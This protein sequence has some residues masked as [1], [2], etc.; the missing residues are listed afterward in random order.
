MIRANRVGWRA[1][2][3]LTKTGG[4]ATVVARL[5]DS[6]YADAAGA[7]V[8]LGRMSAPIHSRAIQV[9]VPPDCAAGSRVSV[10][11]TTL[12]PW[13]PTL[14]RLAPDAAV[15]RAR[16]LRRGLATL[17]APRGL[18]CL[19][20]ADA[21][22]TLVAVRAAPHVRALV[23]AVATAEHCSARHH[24]SALLGLGDGL[25]P[26]GDDYLGGLLFARFV[27]ERRDASWDA[28]I[29]EILAEATARTHPI[30]A[31]LLEDLARGEGWEPLYEI[32]HADDAVAI[33]AARALT[34]IGAATGWNVLAGF[35]TGLAAWTASH[36]VLDEGALPR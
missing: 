11:V 16:R 25:T 12:A 36:G 14:A 26:D 15:K 8:W 13:R 23:A 6:L 18:A 21:V 3:A 10:D 34:T 2:A 17:G 30:S 35:I 27:C 31:C 5:T 32:A 1:H 28:D 29:A 22:P 4:R 9:G 20:C 7:L 33:G 24:A 19:L